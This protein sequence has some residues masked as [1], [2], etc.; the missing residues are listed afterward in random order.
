[1][2]IVEFIAFILNTSVVLQNTFVH[3]QKTQQNYLFYMAENPMS[4]KNMPRYK[5]IFIGDQAVGKTSI[6]TRFVYE[7]F[8][9]SH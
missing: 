1:L 4:I 6:V 8:A 2:N 7:N 3:N 5:V 9:K